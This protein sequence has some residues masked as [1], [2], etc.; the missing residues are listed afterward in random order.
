MDG[1]VGVG[2]D[3][4]CSVFV[5][6]TAAAAAAASY[7]VGFVDAVHVGST[8]LPVGGLVFLFVIFAAQVAEELVHCLRAC[9]WGGVGR[10]GEESGTVER[11]FSM[12]S[13]WACR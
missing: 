9:G 13:L 3:I 6:F 10:R 5:G 4:L 12:V 1:R 8:A 7:I 11:Y 2:E